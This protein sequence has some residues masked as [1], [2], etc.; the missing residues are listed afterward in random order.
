MKIYVLGCGMERSE[1]KGNNGKGY[2]EDGVAYCCRDCAED[3]ECACG[4]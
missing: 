1:W 2:Y 4:L 3:I